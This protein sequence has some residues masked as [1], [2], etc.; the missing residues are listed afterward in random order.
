MLGLSPI[1]RNPQ[2]KLN[3]A[4]S[5]LLVRCKKQAISLRDSKSRSQFHPLDTLSVR[6]G[7]R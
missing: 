5:D 3:D 2:I 1:G 6:F 4:E 7:V